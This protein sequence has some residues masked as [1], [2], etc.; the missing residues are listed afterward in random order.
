MASPQGFRLSKMQ[1]FN[2]LASAQLEHRSVLSVG[3]FDGVHLGHQ[4]LFGTIRDIARARDLLAGAVALDPHPR[5][6]LKPEL[7]MY[8][9]T[10]AEER[11]ELLE[12]L[13][14]DFLVMQPFSLEFSHT[15]ARQFVSLMRHNL[16][17]EVLVAGPDFALGH[18]REGDLPTLTR[19]GEEMGF[20]VEVVEP[21][22]MEGVPVRST[23]I[24][25]LIQEG[26]MPQANHLLGRPFTI[27]SQA[28][29]A[30][31]NKVNI[32]VREKQILPP[33]GT[34]SARLVLR[35]S[36]IPAEV[37]IGVTGG[38]EH[39]I[40]FELQRGAEVNLGR[41]IKVEIMECLSPKL[42]AVNL[43]EFAARMRK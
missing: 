8:Y 7:P 23:I 19:M 40:E 41:E 4:H 31:S 26:F 9:L 17:M 27:A 36:R 29:P 32:K 39:K 12:K 15:T 10:T 3:V 18:D 6:I 38:E 24:R 5:E 43:A 37:R 35:G 2:S 20:E 28:S 11:I 22:E 25:S 14:L 34:Y 16:G 21:L 13:G 1:L 42:G 30:Y 33:Q